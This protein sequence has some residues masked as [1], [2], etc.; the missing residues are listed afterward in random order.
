MYG[1][2]EIVL[3]DY[4]QVYDRKK[5]QGSPYYEWGIECGLGWLKF[6]VQF[7]EF[8][9]TV[10][11][12]E[13]DLQILQIKSKCGS[14]R[15]YVEVAKEVEETVEAFLEELESLSQ[16]FCEA[17]G[18]DISVGGEHVCDPVKVSVRYHLE[19]L[20]NRVKK[21]PPRKEAH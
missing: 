11:L 15:I 3:T 9:D 6:L 12:T 10:Q 20:S 4:F 2:L 8:L 17:C 18:E 19:W 21:G 5:Y 7:A 13:K 14:L 16:G 1:E